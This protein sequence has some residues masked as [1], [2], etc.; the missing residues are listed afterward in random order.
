[1]K[2]HALLVGHVTLKKN[3]RKQGKEHVVRIFASLEQNVVLV[4]LVQRVNVK[5]LESSE[6]MAVPFQCV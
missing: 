1:V 6:V 2:N 3:A 4:V 5:Y